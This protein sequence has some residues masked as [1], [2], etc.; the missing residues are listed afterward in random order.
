VDQFLLSP[1]RSICTLAV[2]ECNKREE[3]SVKVDRGSLISTAAAAQFQVVVQPS[4]MN[5][6]TTIETKPLANK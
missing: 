6:T 1:N 2:S 5:S 4:T 3:Q